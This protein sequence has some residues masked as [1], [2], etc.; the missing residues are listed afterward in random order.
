MA[1]TSE[2]RNVLISTATKVDLIE[3]WIGNLPCHQIPPVC[4]QESRL[5]SLE[6]TRA[7]GIGSIITS[8]ILSVVAGIS[9]LLT[10][11]GG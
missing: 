6:T 4:T 5:K 7:R 11:I 3:G 8:I 10:R 9:Y 1:F 2:D